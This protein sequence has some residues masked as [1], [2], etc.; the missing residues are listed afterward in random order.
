MKILI[1]NWSYLHG[2]AEKQAISDASLLADEHDVTL[3]TF[4]RGPLEDLVKLPVNK[5]NTE[6]KSYWSAIRTVVKVIKDTDADVIHASLFAP[7]VVAAIAAFFTGRKVIWHFHSH[8]SDIPWRSRIAFRW[9]AYLPSV[10]K[11]LF[12]NHELMKYFSPYGFP[13][14]KTNVLYNHSELTPDEEVV[15]NTTGI[16]QIGYLG[17]VVGLKRVQLLPELAQY[18]YR[19]GFLNFRIHIVGDGEALDEVKTAVIQ[20]GL[21]EYFIFHGFQSQVKEYYRLFDF[22]VNPSSE[23][24]LSIAMID[25]GM[26]S[27]PIVAFDVGGNNEIVVHGKT[28]YIVNTKDE[29]FN[30]CYDLAINEAERASMGWQAA[31]HC[32]AL[33]SKERH[34]ADIENLYS[35]ILP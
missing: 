16:L 34:L 15:K 23:E 21:S 33:F 1:L 26:S 24:C 5:I 28:G 2:G 31:L 13:S 12:V 10:R 17:R 32:K 18:L 4:N 30:R 29:F 25:A 7:M 27:L 11:V 6:F 3:L 9:L 22:F 20:S 8:E 19:K 14:K 35:E